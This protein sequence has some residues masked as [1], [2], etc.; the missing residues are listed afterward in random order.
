MNKYRIEIDGL[1]A[2]A[3]IPVILYHISDS[4]VSHGFL[5]VDV[6]FIFSGYLITSLISH[7][8]QS[9]TFSY[10]AHE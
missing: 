8:I 1:R 3:V 9:G 7:Q 2:I 6:F 4:F 10:H 5:G